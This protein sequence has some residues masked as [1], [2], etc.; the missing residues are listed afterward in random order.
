MNEHSTHL[1]SGAGHSIRSA[2]LKFSESSENIA[3]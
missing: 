2:H 3:W 1:A